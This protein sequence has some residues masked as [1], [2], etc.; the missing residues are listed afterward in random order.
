MTGGVG[1]PDSGRDRA[2]LAVRWIL[3]LQCL[4]SGLNWWFKILPFPNIAEPLVLPMKSEIVAT[5]IKSGWMFTAAK[6]IETGLAISLLTN[7]FTVLMLVVAF[8]VL[9]MTF[10]LDTIPFLL[11]IPKWIVGDMT[12][13]NMWA[14]FLDMLFFGGSVFFMQIYL[15]LEW[16]NRYVPMFVAR[17]DD[18]RPAVTFEWL[19]THALVPLRWV[20]I[21]LGLV[22]TLWFVGMI[23][24][25]LIPWK[26][27]A[28]LAP[29]KP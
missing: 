12:G 18:A 7:R 24:Q 14:A 11:G 10:L 19:R 28:L 4:M 21:P 8:P 15:M 1:L 22:A 3:G 20:A 27:L 29:V 2:I 5:M 9:M 23:D 26:S 13:R 17:P 25:W 16:V 6:C